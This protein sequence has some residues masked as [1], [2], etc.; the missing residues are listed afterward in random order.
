MPYFLCYPSSV[1]ARQWLY[2]PS[3]T[4]A[5]AFSAAFGL[6]T[7]IHI[8]QAFIYRKKF[9]IVAITGALWET[10]GYIFRTLSVTRQLDPAYY[11]VQALFLL[12]APLW[13]NAYVYMVVGRMAHFYLFNDRIF[14]LKARHFTIVFV[15][16][17]ITC[18]GVQVAGATA[19]LIALTAA[20]TWTGIDIYITG[21]ALQVFFLILFAVLSIRFWFRLRRQNACRPPDEVVELARTIEGRKSLE[22]ATWLLGAV[23]TALFLI[24]FRNA[25]RIAEYTGGFVSNITTHE[26]PT[27]AFDSVPMFVAVVGFNILNPGHFLQGPRCDFSEEN[28]LRKQ[29]RRRKK[30]QRRIQ[31][32]SINVSYNEF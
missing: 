1:P 28:K 11:D 30:S 2:C 10:L 5:T 27:L 14:G 16:F 29:K 26:W 23:L 32:D 20:Q 13:I 25:Y 17:D 15:L 7:L 21:V 4:A 8:L 6:S 22:A 19:A 9:A 3:F 12:L 31:E 24:I 18:F